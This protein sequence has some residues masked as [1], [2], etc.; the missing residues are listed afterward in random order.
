MPTH[1]DFGQGFYLTDIPD[2]AMKM[3]NRVARIFGGEPVVTC[4][5]ADIPSMLSGGIV[6][7]GF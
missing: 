1:K 4:F 2:Q 6:R 5:E 3:A 7:S